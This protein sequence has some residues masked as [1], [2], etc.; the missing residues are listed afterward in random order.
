MRK[1]TQVSIRLEWIAAMAHLASEAR[2]EVPDAVI[3]YLTDG[4]VA[5]VP[6]EGAAAFGSI[7]ADIDRREA[8]HAEPRVRRAA[9]TTKKAERERAAQTETPIPGYLPALPPAD[10]EERAERCEE[11]SYFD[12]PLLWHCKPRLR[13]HNPRE[14]AQTHGAIHRLLSRRLLIYSDKSVIFA[15]R[16]EI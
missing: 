16:Y 9:R 11:F 5:D 15:D 8:K 6:Q 14:V 4:T 7:R 3:A 1:K 2:H 12:K 10:L 13:S